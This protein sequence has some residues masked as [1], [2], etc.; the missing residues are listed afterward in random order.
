MKDRIKVLELGKEAASNEI[1][2]IN[3]ELFAED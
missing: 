1:A 2:E 3:K